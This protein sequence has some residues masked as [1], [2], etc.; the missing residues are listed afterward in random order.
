MG[1]YKVAEFHSTLHYSFYVN[2]I[3]QFHVYHPWY[4]QSLSLSESPHK[5]LIYK[6]LVQI[7]PLAKLPSQAVDFQTQCLQSAAQHG[8]LHGSEHDK[9][10]LACMGHREM[11]VSSTDVPGHLTFT[12]NRIMQSSKTIAK[13]TKLM[14]NYRIR[15]EESWFLRR[16][17]LSASTL[18]TDCMVK[19][20]RK[21]TL[22]KEGYLQKAC[23]FRCHLISWIGQPFCT[24]ATLQTLNVPCP[25]LMFFIIPQWLR[26]RLN[27]INSEAQLPNFLSSN[28]FP[29]HS[30]FLLCYLGQ[31]WCPTKAW[32]LIWIS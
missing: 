2:V 19:V 32:P 14:V 4:W 24:S 12:S 28:C 29:L 25:F 21:R 5:T 15:D 30:L 11:S 17:K 1:R 8:I 9:R 3:A 26:K 31:V 6:S 23:R 18:V 10:S 20:G 13:S 27:W 7:S 22:A 16:M